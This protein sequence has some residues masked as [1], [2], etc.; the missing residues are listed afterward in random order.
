MQEDVLQGVPRD[1]VMWPGSLGAFV[2]IVSLVMATVGSARFIFLL[3]LSGVLSSMFLCWKMP[4]G[5]VMRYARRLI[6][7]VAV[8]FL[9]HAF[10]TPGTPFFRMWIL[11]PTAEGVRVGFLYS[12]K[13]VIFG[14]GAY[15]LFA[16]IDPF[17]LVSPVQVAARSLGVLTRPIYLLS[18]AFF[19][20]FRFMPLLKQETVS[21]LLALKTKGLDFSGS[22]HGRAKMMSLVIVPVLTSSIKRAEM[23]T[24]SLAMK[25]YGTRHERAVM[26]PLGSV[27]GCVVA[28]AVSMAIL[29]VGWSW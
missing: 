17:E 10:S 6:W 25:G 23:V 26:A 27:S 24:W 28:F 7:I 12:L 16:A 2:L 21:A 4:I 18:M 9:I 22:L 3:V 8:V 29:Y 14:C 19:L 13:F 5:D 20:A 15:L 1:R 11:A